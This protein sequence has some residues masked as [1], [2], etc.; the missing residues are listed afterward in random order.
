V[1]KKKLIQ[2]MNESGSSLNDREEDFDDRFQKT[3]EIIKDETLS[4]E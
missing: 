1:N 3:P 4:P 2:Q